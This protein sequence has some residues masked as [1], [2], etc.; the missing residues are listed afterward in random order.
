MEKLNIDA[1]LRDLPKP[2]RNALSDIDDERKKREKLL[3]GEIF[4]EEDEKKIIRRN[5]ERLTKVL[6]LLYDFEDEP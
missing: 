6:A 2:I 3:G 5:V 1:G 4:L